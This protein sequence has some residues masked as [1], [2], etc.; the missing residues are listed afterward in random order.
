[1]PKLDNI[2]HEKFAHAVVKE[3]SAAEA[4]RKVYDPKANG[5]AKANA[6]RLLTNDTVR[7]RVI[8]LMDIQGLSL[9]RLNSELETCVSD[10]DNN[11]KLKAVQTGYR[12]QGAIDSKSVNSDNSQHLTINVNSNEYSGL[13]MDE[14]IK[15]I[16]DLLK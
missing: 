16:K 2:R 8:A 6:S 1:M 11:V 13:P 15:I 9:D 4:Y 12:L 3:R 5:T 10:S 7:A 14:K